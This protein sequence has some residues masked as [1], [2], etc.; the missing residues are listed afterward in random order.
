MKNKTILIVVASLV[1][2]GCSFGEHFWGST[3][4]QQEVAGRTN[5]SQVAEENI[6]R[7]QATKKLAPAPAERPA[8]EK[9]AAQTQSAVVDSSSALEL[10]WQV[11]GE[12]VDT[13]HIHYGRTR[14]N[15]DMNVNVSVT[16]LEK[17]DHPQYGPV[18]RYRLPGVTSAEKVY[19]S[20]QAE[21]HAGISPPSDVIEIQPGKGFL[22][23]QTTP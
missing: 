17:Y 13:Y 23:S 7:P 1:L 16:E 19:L 6:V 14:T 18:F 12:A 2:S 21:N 20:L 3:D 9:T 4:E 5:P 10:L 8:P 22:S 11:P 15:L